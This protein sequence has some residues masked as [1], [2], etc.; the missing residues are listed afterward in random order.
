M[1]RTPRGKADPESNPRA[2]APPQRPHL[3]SVA[4]P[5][6]L[7]HIMQRMAL[8]VGGGSASVRRARRAATYTP[9]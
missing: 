4:P 6:V 9:V 8:A 5:R 3:R 1:S 2:H 7:P